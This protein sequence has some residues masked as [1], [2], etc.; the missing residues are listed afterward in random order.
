VEEEANASSLTPKKI[1]I[2]GRVASDNDAKI[3][4]KNQDNQENEERINFKNRRGQHI[5]NWAQRKGVN[6]NASIQDSIS[7]GLSS[8]TLELTGAE[9]KKLIDNNQDNSIAGIELWA[10][11]KEESLSTAMN[12]TSISGTST[13]A[14]INNT[15]TR[16]NGVGVYM[17][18]PG[19]ANS[20]AITSYTRLSGS[21]TDHAL[22]VGSIIRAVSP[23]A[24][25][26]CRAGMQLPT[27][28]ELAGIN[29][30][31][32]IRIITASAYSGTINTNYTTMDRDWDDFSYNNNVAMFKSAG[33]Y[34]SVDNPNNTVT[35]P[36]KGLNLITVGNYVDSSSTINST[37]SYLDPASKNAK[38]EVAAP[39]TSI[40]AGGITMTGTSQA[41]P[42]AAAMAAD[43]LSGNSV[44]VSR[45]YLLKAKLIAG[46]IDS[47]TGGTDKVGSG[48]IDFI[49]SYYNGYSVY[50]SGSNA[51][52]NTVD[53][54]DG[55]S[56]STITRQFNIDAVKCKKARF[57]I[58]WATRGTYTYAN[59]GT[60]IGTDFDLTVLNP[61]GT[62][63]G[64]SVSIYNSFE[65]VSF[66]P[67][68]S[69]NYTVKINRYSNKDTS[70]NFKLGIVMS[71]YS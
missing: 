12:A 18:E 56:D 13:S 15:A 14:A 44:F 40:N 42:H 67:S 16:G 21:Q 5:L 8:V 59:V 9:I 30:N 70:S 41:A 62:L 39:G 68:V 29:G 34:H 63:I 66:S 11:A 17:T 47:I 55:V 31:S 23:S 25:L 32:P 51:Y 46:A 2:N 65:A 1:K 22:N 4:F 71:C 58:S 50:H 3:H 10:P 69:G 38:P 60:A 27:I 49:G 35:T 36:G 57:A 52:F 43:M 28:A 45:P 64:S 20:T 6:S 61:S 48:G 24:Y 26:Y 7:R 53:A 54:Q 37:S 33:N 19:C